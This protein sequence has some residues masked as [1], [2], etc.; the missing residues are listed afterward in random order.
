[1]L[2]RVVTLSDGLF[3]SLICFLNPRKLGKIPKPCQREVISGGFA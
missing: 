1:M 3:V 2:K